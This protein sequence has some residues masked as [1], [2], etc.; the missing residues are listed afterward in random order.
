MITAPEDILF[1][2]FEDFKLAS[3]DKLVI[4]GIPI[5]KTHVGNEFQEY[6]SAS[7]IGLSSDVY[8]KEQLIPV[9]EY[10]PLYD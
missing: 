4:F 1:E 2:E 7:A 9:A 5:I 3:K 8:L 10:I 6:S